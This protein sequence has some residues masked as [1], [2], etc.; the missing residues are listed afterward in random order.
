MIRWIPSMALLA[1]MAIPALS[2]AQDAGQ[3]KQIFDGKDLEGW[4]HVGPGDFTVQDGLLTT[5]GGMGLLW[6]TPEKIGNAQIRVVFKTTAPDSNS[7]VFIRIPETP[8]EPWMPVNK[9]YE[10]QIDNSGDDYHCTGVLYSLTKAMARSQKP[11]GDWNTMVITLNGPRTVVELN[12]VKITD[13]T[14]GQPVPP[15]KKNY[16]PDRGLRPDSGYIGLQNH[17]GNTP[18]IFREV[19]IRSVEP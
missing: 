10:V 12:G 2:S 17:P 19:A 6:Y 16:E 7:G 5:Q 8:T 14:E 9:G 13:Y 3:W 15:K 11:P 4:E 18:V 1:L